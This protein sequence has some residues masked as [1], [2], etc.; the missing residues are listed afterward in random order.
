[1]E[2]KY[3]KLQFKLLFFSFLYKDSNFAV[4]RDQF[5]LEMKYYRICEV[6][7]NLEVNIN[8]FYSAYCTAQCAREA[9]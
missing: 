2:K 9:N 7:L 8:K 1:M 5:E 4:V 3:I 6:G